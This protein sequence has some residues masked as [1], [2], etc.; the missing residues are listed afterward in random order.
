MSVTPSQYY[1]SGRR[2]AV[3]TSQPHSLADDSLVPL[4]VKEKRPRR[5]LDLPVEILDCILKEARRCTAA[6]AAL[7]HFD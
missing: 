5:L 6:T 7:A 3:M 1:Q 4:S 2:H